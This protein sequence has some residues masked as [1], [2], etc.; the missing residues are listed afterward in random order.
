M[1]DIG[2]NQQVIVIFESVGA[3]TALEEMLFSVVI[4]IMVMYLV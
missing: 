2:G 4:C 3:L 1:E